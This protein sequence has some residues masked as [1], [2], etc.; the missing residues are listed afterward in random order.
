[1]IAVI[2]AITYYVDVKKQKKEA[3]KQ[4]INKYYEG[5]GVF[6][7]KRALCLL[8]VKIVVRLLCFR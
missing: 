5:P 6:L 7:A 1:M 8:F 4:A 2:F 3:M